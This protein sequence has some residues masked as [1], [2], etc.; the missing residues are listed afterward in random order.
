MLPTAHSTLRTGRDSQEGEKEEK[1]TRQGA[2][3]VR[4]QR[5]AAIAMATVAVTVLAE[6]SSLK[7]IQAI[8][9]GSSSSVAHGCERRW[10]EGGGREGEGG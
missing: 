5:A 7:K 2:W 3:R 4:R 6:N 8:T 1:K 10:K 9:S